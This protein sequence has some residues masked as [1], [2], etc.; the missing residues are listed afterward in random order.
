[1]AWIFRC[2]LLKRHQQCSL[3]PITQA[4]PNSRQHKT[5]VRR[6]ILPPQ[7]HTRPQRTSAARHTGRDFRIK[8]RHQ[9]AATDGCA[10]HVVPATIVSVRSST[11]RGVAH[12][13]VG[14]VLPGRGPCRR[15][16]VEMLV[17]FRVDVVSPTF[18]PPDELLEVLNVAEHTC[19]HAGHLC[20]FICASTCLSQLTGSEAVFL[21]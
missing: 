1:M 4:D 16:V 7:A 19:A 6:Q 3:L 20:P 14:R 9:V 10:G 12:G 2:R 8:V 5:K 17:L 13:R 18:G 15:N 11:L 21:C